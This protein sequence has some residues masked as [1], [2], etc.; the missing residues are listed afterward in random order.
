[1]RRSRDPVE[2]LAALPT[3]QARVEPIAEDLNR[4]KRS[5]RFARI[6]V[7]TLAEQ[8]LELQLDDGVH[9]AVAPRQSLAECCDPFPNR[10]HVHL[11]E[12][13]VTGARWATL[14]SQ[15]DRI[16]DGRRKTDLK[17][18]PKEVGLIELALTSE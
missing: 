5:R 14:Q 7:W 10:D 11:L 16:D 12:G 13:H 1:M 15:S 3:V 9:E 17:L 6:D 2:E 8:L 4:S 18:T